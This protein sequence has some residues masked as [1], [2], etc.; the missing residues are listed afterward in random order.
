MLQAMYLGCK[1]FHTQEGHCK[2][3]SLITQLFTLKPFAHIV[4]APG[5]TT[6]MASLAGSAIADSV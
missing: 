6:L 2:E 3:L 5:V 1:F 4:G